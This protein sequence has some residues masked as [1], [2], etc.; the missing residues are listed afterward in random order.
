MANRKQ[1]AVYFQY[2]Q[3]VNQNEIVSLLGSERLPDGRIAYTLSDMNVVSDDLIY[4]LSRI[5]GSDVRFNEQTGEYEE[6]PAFAKPRPLAQYKVIQVPYPDRKCYNFFAV[7]SNNEMQFI[8]QY[9]AQGRPIGNYPNPRFNPSLITSFSYENILPVPNDFVVSYVNFVNPDEDEDYD[10]IDLSDEEVAEEMVITPPQIIVS[11]EQPHQPK[12][13]MMWEDFHK[14]EPR[15]ISDIDEELI[16][17][18]LKNSKKK[19]STLSIGLSIELPVKTI[20]DVV[21]ATFENPDEHIN[22]MCEKLVQSVSTEDIKNKM[23]EIIL[24]LYTSEAEVKPKKEKPVRLDDNKPREIGDVKVVPLNEK[25]EG[26]EIT[27]EEAIKVTSKKKDED[28]PLASKKVKSKDMTP[29]EIKARRIENLRKA[30]EAK[31]LKA[32][33]EKENN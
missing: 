18:I 23:K 20:V 2:I 25:T 21:R 11:E 31:K 7:D 15:A 14:E 33:Q 3:G 4:P 17:R 32:L 28:T 9:D 29:E 1:N 24:D 16:T 5:G 8:K 10:L 22:R 26:K 30:R 6:V 13:I 27:L 12:A 19:D